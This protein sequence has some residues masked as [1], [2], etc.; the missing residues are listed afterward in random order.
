MSP[1]RL[2][3]ESGEAQFRALEKEI[4]SNLMTLNSSVIATGGG[5]L[6]DPENIDALKANG[7]LIFIDRPLRELKI[8]KD[9]P[10]A[11]TH[12]D[13]ERLYKTRIESYLKADTV[14][15]AEGKS[16]YD[17]ARYIY[18]KPELIYGN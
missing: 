12:E 9:R 6:V 7:H 2:I 3:L 1:A 5:S 15:R 14:I 11:K 17:L 18:E 13:L 16:S 4:I 10:I 8:S